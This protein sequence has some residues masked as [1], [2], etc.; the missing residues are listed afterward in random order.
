MSTYRGDD[1]CTDI[2]LDFVRILDSGGGNYNAIYGEPNASDDLGKKTLAEIYDLQRD[3]IRRG[4]PST[5]VGGYQFL[6]GTL[7]DLARTLALTEDTLFTPSLQ[8]RMAFALLIRRGYRKWWKG[9]IG[10]TAFAH[11]LAL[12]W[13]S[14]PDPE[15]GGRSAYDGVAGNHAGT[16]LDAVYAM[17]AR[18]RAAKPGAVADPPPAAEPSGSDIAR[19]RV[20]LTEAAEIAARL[21]DG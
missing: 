7:Q 11:N 8:D 6:R 14:M 12:E 20:L 18:A 15:K 16:T 19:L 13:A 17:L 10:D 5:A 3:M 4:L 21:G 9:E 2:I 1:N